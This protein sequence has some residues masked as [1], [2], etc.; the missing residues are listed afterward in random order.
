[1]GVKVIP[2]RIRTVEP[3]AVVLPKEFQTSFKP[4]ARNQILRIEFDGTGT[5]DTPPLFAKVQV[6]GTGVLARVFGWLF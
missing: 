1:M 2:G 6:R 4:V 3:L 5:D